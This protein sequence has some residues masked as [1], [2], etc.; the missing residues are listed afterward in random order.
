MF[1]SLAFLFEGDVLKKLSKTTK[2]LHEI[3][4]GEKKG[5]ENR[6]ECDVFLL[7]TVRKI[8][9]EKKGKL[10]IFLVESCSVTQP[11]LATKYASAVEYV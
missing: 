11:H 6:V 7:W 9:G 2:K 8:E 4:E 10:I 3:T 1:G 5:N